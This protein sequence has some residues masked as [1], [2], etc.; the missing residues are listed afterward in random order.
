MAVIHF[1]WMYEIAEEWKLCKMVGK[2]EYVLEI[3]CGLCSFTF[4]VGDFNAQCTFT[5]IVDLGL[6]IL[7]SRK[8]SHICA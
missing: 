4:G 6:L 5:H 3:P 8:R 7:E 1:D 2:C